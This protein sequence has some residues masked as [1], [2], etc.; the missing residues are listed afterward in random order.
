MDNK[1]LQQFNYKIT[2]DRTVLFKLFNINFELQVKLDEMGVKVQKKKNSAIKELNDLIKK[3]PAVP[4]FKNYLSALY[5]LQGNHFMASEVNRRIVSSH[6]DYLYGKLNAANNAI[7]EGEFDQVP[8]ILGDSLDIKA[9][10]PEREEFHIGE[11]ISFLKTSFNYYIGIKDAE[12]AQMRLD[13]IRTL[14]KEFDLDE[15][16]SVLEQK[17]RELDLDIRIKKRHDE[18]TQLRRPDVIPQKLVEP[19][20]EKPVFKH[21]IINELYCNSME[22]DQQIIAE[23]LN[24]PRETLIA[25][26]QKVV[27]DSIARLDV[28]AAMD[29]DVQTHELMMHAMLLLVE[30]NDEKS[31]DIMLDVLRQDHD[32]LEIWFGDFITEGFWELLYPVAHD[33]L[34]KL[35]DF[36]IE[37]NGY[38]FSKSCVSQMVQQIV[39]HQPGRRAE[40]VGWYKRVFDFWIA[41]HEND[42][43][44]DNELIAFLISD[45][46]GVKLNELKS[47]MSKLYEHN[48]VA[49]GVCGS[50]ERCLESI[51]N[52]KEINRKLDLFNSIEERYHHYKT[53]WLNYTGDYSPEYDEEFEDEED[54]DEQV[55]E[56]VKKTVPLPG[57]KPKVGRNEPCPCGSG[58]KYKKC[59]GK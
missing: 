56:E 21:A 1:T 7:S 25:D 12:S 27:Y 28:F 11:V 32:Y 37:P 41:N 45:A 42:D 51:N 46:V 43:V 38:T 17:I 33:K 55:Y 13:L 31:L 24:L 54:F 19:T 47:E 39:L 22:I 14:D 8:E 57:D 50:L 59:C 2:T 3:Y 48:L 18:W 40:V 10:Y 30:L 36:V 49:I 16:I 29:W 20:T 26:L 52:P 4:Q 23:I 53:T 6:P 9:L 15:E 35:Y 5:S 58:K 44:I 34:D